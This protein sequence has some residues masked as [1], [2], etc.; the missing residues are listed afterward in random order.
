MWLL[1]IGHTLSWIDWS[2]NLILTLTDLINLFPALYLFNVNGFSVIE[3]L[4]FS[5]KQ[6]SHFRTRFCFIK[7]LNEVST[8]FLSI[9]IVAA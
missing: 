7:L 3:N 4:L 9:V 8:A 2:I 5:L 6:T 1:F